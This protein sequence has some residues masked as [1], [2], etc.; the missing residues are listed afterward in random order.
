[1][2]ILDLCDCKVFLAL[3]CF[4]FTVGVSMPWHVYGGRRATLG[5][6]L[7]PSRDGTPGVSLLSLS[8]TL[9]LFAFRIGSCSEDHTSLRFSL[10]EMTISCIK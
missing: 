6:A 5:S 10:S 8:P 2:Y 7:S 3:S 9:V 4:Q 1:M